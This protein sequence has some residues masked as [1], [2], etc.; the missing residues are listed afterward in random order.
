LP[1]T[2]KEIENVVK[3]LIEN[4][5]YSCLEDLNNRINDA[6][7]TAIAIYKTKNTLD[8]FVVRSNFFSFEELLLLAEIKPDNQL[9]QFARNYYF[10]ITHQLP[11]W[12]MRKQQKQISQMSNKKFYHYAREHPKGKAIM[13][14]ISWN[15]HRNQYDTNRYPNRKKFYNYLRTTE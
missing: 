8:T 4:R 6:L 14:I 10:G 9:Q 11:A 3:Q 5:Q 7:E 12:I 15:K 13:D 1:T 2:K